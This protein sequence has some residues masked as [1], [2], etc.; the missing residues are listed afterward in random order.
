[1]GDGHYARMLEWNRQMHARQ[2][3][4]NAPP[5]RVEHWANRSEQSGPMGDDDMPLISGAEMAA[6]LR[7][8]EPATG[9]YWDWAEPTTGNIIDVTPPQPAIVDTVPALPAP[10][11][12]RS[13]PPIDPDATQQRHA[14][15]TAPD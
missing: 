10:T 11:S 5:E 4:H 15:T 3:F 2:Y 9:P 7:E 13:C 12:H 6:M 14:R 8:L 1:M